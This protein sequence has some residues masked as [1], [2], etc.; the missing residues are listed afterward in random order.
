MFKFCLYRSQAQ[1][2]ASDQGLILGPAI[3]DEE[4][5]PYV[6]VANWKF[7]IQLWKQ[8]IKTGMGSLHV[9]KH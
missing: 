6:M 3:E 4:L 2:I 7:Y 5:A 1:V 9:W 8:I